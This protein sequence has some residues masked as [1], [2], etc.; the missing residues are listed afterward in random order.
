MREYVLIGLLAVAAVLVAVGAGLVS[1][2]LGL[3]VG[4]VE[5]AALALFALYGDDDEPAPVA[6]AEAGP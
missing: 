2:A 3:A 5:L 1:V 4:G 6:E